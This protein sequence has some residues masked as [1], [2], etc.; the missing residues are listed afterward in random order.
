MSLTSSVEADSTH[1]GFES[2]NP[3]CE[4]ICRTCSIGGEL[5]LSPWTRTT[6][7]IGRSTLWGAEAYAKP[8]L[9]SALGPH[10]RPQKPAYPLPVEVPSPVS[11]VRASC[12]QSLLRALSVFYFEELGITGSEQ[13]LYRHSLPPPKSPEI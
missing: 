9:G 4:T 2:R 5:T 11:P 12:Q 10:G 6:P 1:L 8:P 13:E 7:W 3:V